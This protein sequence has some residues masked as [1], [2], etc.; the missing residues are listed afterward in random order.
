MSTPR[1][2]PTCRG[3]GIVNARKRPDDTEAQGEFLGR[4][5]ACNGKGI[6]WELTDYLPVPPNRTFNVKTR[7]VYRGKGEPAPFDLHAC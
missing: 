6:V 7:Y 5:H 2:C 1:P 3:K 4:C